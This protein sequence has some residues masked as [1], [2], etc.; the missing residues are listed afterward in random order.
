MILVA[1]KHVDGA[2][3][4]DPR[5]QPDAVK[6]TQLDYRDAIRRGLKVMDT[7]A[8]ALCMDNR[9]PSLVFNLED[10]S[11]IERAVMGEPVGTLVWDEESL[12]NIA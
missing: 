12:A 3:E 8:L 5:T 11:N 6:F 1:K 7:A 9:M 4:A 10:E 2:Y